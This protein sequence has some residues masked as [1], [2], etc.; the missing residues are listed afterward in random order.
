MASTHVLTSSPVQLN[1][2]TQSVLL[3]LQVEQH[4]HDETYHREIARLSLHQRL[5]HMALHFSKYTGKIAQAEGNIQTTNATFT[6]AFIIALSTANILNLELCE[7]LGAKCVNAPSVASYGRSLCRDWE[8]RIDE[9]N[10]ILRE[11][12]VASGRVSAACEKIDHLEP[13]SFR[14]EISAGLTRITEV[15]IAYLTHVG[16]DP[17]EAVRKRLASVKER[18]KLHGRI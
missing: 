1:K 7:C 2:T 4:H 18:L 16:V 12:A 13:V 11:M 17:V 3:D 9:S 5:N 14:S 15:S 8:Q 10:W 6:D